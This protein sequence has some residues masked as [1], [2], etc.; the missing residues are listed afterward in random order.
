GYAVVSRSRRRPRPGPQESWPRIRGGVSMKARR[1]AEDPTCPICSKPVR[2]GASEVSEHGELIHTRCRSQHLQLRAIEQVDRAQK[3][4]N[5]EVAVLKGGGPGGGGPSPVLSPAWGT[6]PPDAGGLVWVGRVT[7]GTGRS[8]E[9]RLGG[10]PP[11][12]VPDGVSVPPLS[13]E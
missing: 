10:G 13:N 11:F 4:E 2:S 5:G 8:R 7:F 6:P 1:P 12:S 3:A 9:L